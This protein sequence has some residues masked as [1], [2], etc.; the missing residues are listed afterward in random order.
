MS[1]YQETNSCIESQTEGVLLL[2]GSVVIKNIAIP[3][4]DVADFMRRVPEEE[5]TAA[6]VQVVQ[7]GAFCLERAQTTKDT[8]F[9]RRQV[10]SLLSEVDT[11]VRRIPALAQAA[12]IE[13]IGG[14]SGQVLAPITQLVADV[15]RVTAT[16]LN[17]VRELLS[18]DIDPGR[19][20]STVG[21]ALRAVRDLLDS[22]RMDSVQGC[23][24]AA[25]AQVTGEDGAL[26]NSVKAVVAEAMRPL[27]SQLLS[28]VME[29]RGRDAAAEAVAQTTAK[30]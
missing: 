20:S 23:I 27:Q 11:A 10:E 24:R 16:K 22:N 29:S 4:R 28:I 9:V 30:E 18:R 14:N 19:E 13:K 12:F 5:R 8:D 21:R 15:S 2:E 3:H 7:I 6:L 26:A 25:V 17:D 1:T